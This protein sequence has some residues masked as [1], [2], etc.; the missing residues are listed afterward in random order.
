MIDQI[1]ADIVV[2]IHLT[3]ILFIIG[4]AAIGWKIAWVKWLHISSLAFSVCLQAFS[5]I[6]PLT[7]LEVWL[8]SRGPDGE[9]YS[10]TFIR[11]TFEKIIYM[12]IPWE[13]TLGLTFVIIG[14]SGYIYLKPLFNFHSKGR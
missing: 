2:A 5:W 7:T 6:C 11:H 10:G 13:L 14:I 12:A 1:A 8:R 4:G 3:W 9:A